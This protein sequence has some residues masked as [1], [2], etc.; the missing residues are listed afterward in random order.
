MKVYIKARVICERIRNDKLLKEKRWQ[1]FVIKDLK[2]LEVND[3]KIVVTSHKKFQGENIQKIF[4]K[5][6]TKTI[7]LEL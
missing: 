3:G 7:I 2:S 1:N 5:S 4:E 6:E